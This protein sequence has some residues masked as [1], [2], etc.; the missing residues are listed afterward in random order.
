MEEKTINKTFINYAIPTIVGM[1]VVSFQTIIDGMFVS[2]GI[3]PYGLASVNLAMPLINVLYS[4]AIMI[5]SGGIVI[6]GIAQGKGDESATKGYTSLTFVIF[7]IASL[8]IS[9]V[10]LLNLR[11]ICYALGADD[12]LFPYLKD[13][14]SIMGAGMFM[15]TI[16]CFTEAFCRLYGEPNKVFVS[17]FVSCVVNIILD[18]IFVLEFGWGMKGAAIAT[19]IANFMAAMALASYVKMGRIIGGKREIMKIFFN[20]SSEMI[21]SVASAV[22]AFVFNIMIMKHIGYLGVAAL[23]IVLYFNMI[24]NFSTMGMAQAMYPL[25]SYSL[26]AKNYVNI[27]HL[28]MIALKY[29]FIIGASVYFIILIFKRPIINLF[30]N[31]NVELAD[32]TEYAATYMT[33]AY[34]VSFINIIGSGFHTAIEKPVES[35]VIALFK[36]FIFSIGVLLILPV[37]FEAVGLDYNLGI[38]LSVPVGEFLCLT[39]TVPLLVHSMRKLYAR[40]Q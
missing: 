6:S 21:T 36:S 35:A 4:I 9:A 15:L 34:F 16:P 33:L 18:W 20:G 30:A 31:G 3:G 2:K 5:V 10:I 39:I 37:T 14:L 40:F 32:M 13:Y 24:V 26:G 25:L 11:S 7:T 19:I 27:R 8:I 38:W 17:G 22:T 1:L 23:T 29:S 28:L 12:S